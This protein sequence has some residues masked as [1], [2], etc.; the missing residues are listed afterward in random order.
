VF[1]AISR[2]IR[3]AIAMAQIAMI[4]QRGL[5]RIGE[6]SNV[7]GVVIALFVAAVLLPV[8]FQQIYNTSTTGWNAAVATVFTVLLPVLSII[9]ISLMFL[10]KISRK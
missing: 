10:R 7:V 9:A 5:V 3:K 8:A 6:V 2:K 4:S 1:K